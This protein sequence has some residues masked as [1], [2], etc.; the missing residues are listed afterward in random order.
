MRKN[1]NLLSQLF[2]S[3]RTTFLVVALFSVAINVLMLTGPLFMLQVYDRVLT[4]QSV[5]TLIALFTLV[6]VL[7]V[8][9]GLFSF[10]RSRVLSNLGYRIDTELMA[11]AN[12]IWLS[13]GIGGNRIESRP[14]SD[15]TTIRHFFSGSGLPAMFDLPWVPFYLGIVY[16]LHPW[17]GMLATVG[18][19]FVVL[20]TVANEFLTKRHIGNAAFRDLQVTNFSE[21]AIKNAEAIFPMGMVANITN[22]W[23]DM[24]LEAMRSAQIAGGRSEI[25]SAL[26]KSSRILLQSTI[27]ALGAYLAILQEI[28]PGTMIACSILAGRALSPVDQA[29]GNWQNFIKSR[30]AYSRLK[31]LPWQ[32]VEKLE[33][34]NLPI[35]AAKISMNN[36]AKFA[37]IGNNP[38]AERKILLQGLNFKLEPGDC[39]GVI[40]PS[41]AGKSCLARVLV[42]LWTPDRGAI[43][44]DGATYDQWDRDK[45]GQHIGYL[46]QSVELMAGTIGQNIARFNPDADD[47]EIVAAA[48]LAGV[49]ELILALAD[50]YSTDLAANPNILSG[51]QSQRVALARA[52]FRMPALVVL[53]EPNANLDSEGDAAMT[54]AIMALRKHGSCVAIMAHRP[55]AMVAVNKVLMMRDGKQMEFGE[56]EQVLQKVTKM[57]S[58]K[59]RQSNLVRK[60]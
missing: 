49:H 36:V 19:I 21:R 44:I 10:I 48:K 8:F 15:L 59:D 28:T 14:V 46:P 47:E 45:L 56:K 25:V 22:Y 7:Y 17:L 34:V 54:N 18:A 16:L 60:K 26:T 43:R 52:V 2:R 27:L 20:A 58:Q 50:G 57:V 40:G 6:V 1:T 5:P 9:M 3:S 55:S 42:G 11:N 24:R 31:A 53:D 12:K 33:F 38:K 51:G 35:P 37:N 23:Q 39:L 30:Q 13:S 32:A 29:I 41:G 4:S